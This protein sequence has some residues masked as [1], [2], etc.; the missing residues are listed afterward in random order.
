MHAKI[1]ALIGPKTWAPAKSVRQK[2]VILDGR[3][4]PVK[5]SSTDRQMKKKGKY[6][7]IHK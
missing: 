6:E 4:P 3:N 7:M 5:H 1:L 2:H